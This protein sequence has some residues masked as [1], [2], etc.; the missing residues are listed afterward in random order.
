MHSLYK[1]IKHEIFGVMTMLYGHIHITLLF[2]K[3]TQLMA[4]ERI[5]TALFLYMLT[6][7]QKKTKKLQETNIG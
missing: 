7:G 6:Y 2:I 5:I 4:K 1:L 3:C